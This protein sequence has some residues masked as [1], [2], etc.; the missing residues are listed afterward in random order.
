[1]AIEVTLPELA[2]GI[3]GGDVVSVLVKEGELIEA[4]APIIE[5]ESEKATVTVPCPVKGRISGILVRPGDKIKVGQTLVLIDQGENSGAAPADSE[6]TA[7][8]PARNDGRIV[9]DRAAPAP[10]SVSPAAPVA[11]EPIVPAPSPPAPIKLMADDKTHM[12][13]TETTDTANS[14]TAVPA[15]PTVRRIARE[16]GIDLT[17]VKGSG[18]NG[19]IVV[20]D[21]DPY[22][23]SAMMK[24]AGVEAAAASP[25][26]TAT[27]ASVQLPDFSLWGPIRRQKIDSI[28]RKIAVHL[29]QA[30][31]GIPH[32]H[33]FHEADITHLI[34]LQ[35]RYRARVKERGGALTLTPFLIKALV[36][37]L[38]EFPRFNASF[39]PQAGEIIFKDYYHIG[40]AV[41]TPSG[42]LVPVIRDADKKSIADLAVELAD[43]SQRT[44]DRKVV[45]DELRGGTFTLTNLGGIGGG[46]FSPIINAPETSILGTG[47][48]V[49]RAVYRKDDTL[50]PR[51]MLP[52]SL[53]YDHRVIDG[54]DGARFIV[55]LADILENFE[56]T[57]LGI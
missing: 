55:K 40:V 46:H 12:T 35:Q 24:R 25:P 22:I 10:K 33:Q 48:A 47:R 4:D 16:L 26:Q 49:K 17:T 43:L 44:R 31:A 53:A 13:T 34:G 15:G 27:I 11:S 2:E 50:E 36:M 18:R 57:C 45:V 56:A 7:T 1:M 29:G 42:L 9:P 38:K 3:S 21:I 20:E 23:Q 5:I 39:D 52:L 37:T 14:R 30:W 41:D 32:V 19:R 28:R 6:P 54:A 51:T 8:A